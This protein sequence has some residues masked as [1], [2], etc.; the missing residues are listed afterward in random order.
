MRTAYSVIIS[1]FWLLLL[2]IL[3]VQSYRIK[4]ALTW[5]ENW[6][7]NGILPLDIKQND[8]IKKIE[9]LLKIKVENDE[10]L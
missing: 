2:V 4:R 6:E 8:R 1:L 7:K 5:Q 10:K 9:E 3:A